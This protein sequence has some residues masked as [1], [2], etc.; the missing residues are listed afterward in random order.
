MFS[1]FFDKERSLFFETGP[2]EWAVIIDTMQRTVITM[3]GTGYGDLTTKGLNMENNRHEQQLSSIAI[4][5]CSGF[6]L[7]SK[8]MKLKL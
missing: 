3:Q 4:A 8:M 5:R 7:F 2:I 1:K 6:V